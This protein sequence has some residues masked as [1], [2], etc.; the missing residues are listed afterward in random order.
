MTVILVAIAASLLL[1]STTI[2]VST[3]SDSG[4][5][6]AE[7]LE[8]IISPPADLRPV[9][10]HVALPEQVKT[11]YMTACALGTVSFREDLID[12]IDTTEVNS[13]M[14]D[15]K[16][17]SGGV[18]FLPPEDS[19]W[20][21]AWK[22]AKCGALDLAEFITTLHDKGIYVIGRITVFQDPYAA[23]MHPDL[24]VKYADGKTVWRDYK[25][26]SFIDVGAREWWV[27]IVEL[28]R[29]SYNL[30]FD[31]LNYDYIR[32][33]S[34]GPMSNVSF[35]H[36]Q[37]DSRADNLENFFIYL[38]EQTK[39]SELYSEVRHENTGRD[40][41]VPYLSADLFGFTTTN[42]DDLSIGQIIERAF[43]YF[44]FIAPMVY[45]SHYPRNYLGLGN[46]NNYPYQVVNHAMASAVA[47]AVATTTRQAAFAHE[48]IG[49]STPAQYKKAAYN[50][51]NLRTWIQ[52]FDYGGDYDAAD[53]RAQIKASYDAGVDSWM[54][55]SPSNK[56]TKAA[57]ESATTTTLS[58]TT[59]TTTIPISPRPNNTEIVAD[60]LL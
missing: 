9:V 8:P 31:E 29:L 2:Y 25:G 39:D 42:Q 41:D 49:T 46:P 27:N 23:K 50:A 21:G 11:I 17:Y 24:A 10:K 34:D 35:P 40:K 36:S 37:S 45:P 53:V 33:P 22:N 6:A 1:T 52:D 28:T 38:S 5:K 57:L 48:R 47:R 26:L 60:D 14:I 54:I 4:A 13:L 58:S 20:H 43:P 18:S 59:S 32:Y 30:G 55:W 7:K 19:I 51:D 3:V 12:L 56:Y 15:I 44:D 16:D